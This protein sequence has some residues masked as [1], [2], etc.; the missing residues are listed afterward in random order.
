MN[1]RSISR[2]LALGLTVVLAL[3]SC[4]RKTVYHHFQHTSLTDWERNDTLFFFVDPMKQ[5]GTVQRDVELR[6]AETFPF[7]KINLVVE[8]TT[9]STCFIRHDTIDCDLIDLEGNFLGDG[10][11]L[12]QYR[13][14]LPD[15]TVNKGDSLRIAIRHNMKRETLPGVSDV[16]LRLTIR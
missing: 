2:W 14:P 3:A 1:S 11:T 10:I 12:F 13:F 9:L 7:Q 5:G 15:I 6:I 16:G 8:Q 4:N